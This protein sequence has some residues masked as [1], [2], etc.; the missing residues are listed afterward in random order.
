MKEHERLAIARVHFAELAEI[1]HHLLQRAQVV[2]SLHREHPTQLWNVLTHRITTL[3]RLASHPPANLE[4]S[5]SKMVK[6][7]DQ[8]HL[9]ECFQSPLHH[10]HQVAIII[11]TQMVEILHRL[12]HLPIKYITVAGAIDRW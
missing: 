4:A 6:R 10:Q 8:S 5:T 11:Y 2:I 9:N 1:V 7:K 3:I 12:H